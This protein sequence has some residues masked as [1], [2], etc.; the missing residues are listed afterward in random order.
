MEFEGGDDDNDDTSLNEEYW[1]EEILSNPQYAALKDFILQN[2][3]AES[4]QGFIDLV[5]RDFEELNT[6]IEN[7][8]V[9]PEELIEKVIMGSENRMDEENQPG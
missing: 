8:D 1:A 4:S 5:E 3:D 2:Q 7:G 6:A 9:D